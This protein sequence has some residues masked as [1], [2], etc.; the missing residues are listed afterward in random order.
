MALVVITPQQSGVSVLPTEVI[1]RTI[2][3]TAADIPSVRTALLTA[4]NLLVGYA[5]TTTHWTAGTDPYTAL[6]RFEALITKSTVRQID[7]AY[8]QETQATVSSPQQ[9]RTTQQAH[10]TK[11]KIWLACK[12]EVS[13]SYR[14]QNQAVAMVQRQRKQ[15]HIKQRR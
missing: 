5:D 9:Q 2:Q 10:F 8:S 3:V 11:S 4:Y 7:N 1:Y 15:S 6:C 12:R 14:K 13:L